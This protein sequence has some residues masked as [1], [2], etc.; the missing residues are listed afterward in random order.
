MKVKKYL[1][2]KFIAKTQILKPLNSEEIQEEKYNEELES[3]N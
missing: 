2:F 3:T 1:K